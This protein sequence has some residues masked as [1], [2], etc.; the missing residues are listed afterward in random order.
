MTV[1]KSESD[2]L[3]ELS[4]LIQ[5]RIGVQ[6]GEKQRHMVESR[7]KGRILELGLRG[8]A[9][10]YDYFRE[11]V[12]LET[13]S[14]ISILTTHHTYFFREFS[15]FEYLENIALPAL[16][17]LVRARADK[18]LHVWS[19]ACSRGQ[20]VYSLAM[21]LDAYLKQHA[22]DIRFDILGTDVDSESVH[23]SR[24]GVYHYRE[25]KEVPIHYLANHWARG[26]GEIAEYVK[27]KKQLRDACR[28]DTLNLIDLD[29]IKKFPNFDVIFCRNV[30]IYFDSEQIR[31]ITTELMQK[32]QPRGYF[33]IGISET[34]HGLNV[35]ATT[36]GPS[37]Y[38]HPKTTSDLGKPAIKGLPTAPPSALPNLPSLIRVLCV[39]D[40]P[41]VLTLLKG[42]FTQAAGFEIVG[43]AINGLDAAK[44]VAELKPHVMT[45]DIHMPEQTGIEYLEKNMNANH[46]PVV[47][48][49]SVSR[50]NAELAAKALELGASDYIEKPALNQLAVRADEI[51]TKVRCAVRNRV[52]KTTPVKSTVDAEFK[53]RPI[54]PTPENKLRLVFGGMSDRERIAATLREGLNGPGFVILIENAG[55]ALPEMARAFEKQ[56]GRPVRAIEKAE[57]PKPGEVVVGDFTLIGEALRTLAAGKQTVSL[58]YGHPSK[59]TVD[60]VRSWKNSLTFVEETGG[61]NPLGSFA[62]DL[63]P[64]TSFVAV[65]DEY[66]SG[67]K[68]IGKVAKAA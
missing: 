6:L 27:I 35:K 52:W 26:T 2:I 1:L 44:K 29:A 19:A 49:S 36:T 41:T 20:E 40:S 68:S 39:D 32:V 34:L 16:I 58:V 53:R 62:K 51:Q 11:N 54:I 15:H 66:L 60:E 43:T 50:E 14:L 57:L 37:I 64:A 17:P 33:F 46:I 31:K 63:F 59:R 56:F 22:S 24:N 7:V 8:F 3:S 30:F 61:A 4:T 18:T 45:L 47:M 65:S 38:T 13:K 67:V 23:L 9:D 10:Y 5:T 55:P 48:V 28:F 21:F 25:I 12:K 42:I